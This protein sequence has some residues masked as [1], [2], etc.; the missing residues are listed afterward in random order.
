MGSPRQQATPPPP[1][2]PPSPDAVPL[3]VAEVFR[4]V[5]VRGRSAS[6]SGGGG[7]SP[8]ASGPSGG[9]FGVRLRHRMAA[10][11]LRAA[12]FGA[13]PGGNGGQAQR[14]TS[15]RVGGRG[16]GAYDAQTE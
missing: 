5:P 2:M 4:S 8:T 10:T 14:P 9:S 12:S 7:N 13:V 1:L 15:L 6:A 16:R 3:P 11:N